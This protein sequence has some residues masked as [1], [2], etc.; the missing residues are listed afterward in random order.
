MT[1]GERLKSLREEQ[2]ISRE[3]LAQK[4]GISYWALSK[5]END[6]REPDYSTLLRLADFFSVSVDYLLCRTNVRKQ[7]TIQ[8]AHRSDGY[9]EP[10]PQEALDELE[11]FK[12]YIRHKYRH[13]KPGMT[14]SEYL[15]KY[16]GDGEGG[17]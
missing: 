6:E 1:L 9:D 8:A 17:D 4:L 5:Y 13:W 14:Q 2:N 16:G 7:P 15:K 3:D 12:D 11:R 10:L